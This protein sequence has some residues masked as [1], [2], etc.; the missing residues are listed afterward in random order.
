MNHI[1]AGGFGGL[2]TTLFGHP[3]DTIKV[4]MQ[5]KP[6]E[7]RNTWDAIFKIISREGPSGLYKGMMAPLVG[8]VPIFGISFF[9]FSLGKQLVAKPNQRNEDLAASQLFLAGTFSGLTTIPLSVPGERIKCL[10]QMQTGRKEAF[11]GFIDCAIK[12]FHGGGIKNL[13]VGTC[14]TI[15]RDLPAS[16]V[17]FSVYDIIM[18]LFTYHFK[19]T[20]MWHSIFAGGFAGMINWV[21]AMPA[22]VLKSRLQISSIDRYPRGMRSLLPEIL[23]E[24]GPWVLYRGVMPIMIR[25]IPANATCFFGIE[26]AMKILDAHFPSL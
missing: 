16:G 20:V 4:R 19:E 11:T 24:E 12:L 21:V 6:N 18:R 9:S 7:Y 5:S 2:C 15:L 3:L 17:Y 14:A 8:I 26:I 13:Y 23:R 10:L 1:L 22:D 25:A